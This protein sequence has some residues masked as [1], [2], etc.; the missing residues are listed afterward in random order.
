MPGD[1]AF[2]RLHTQNEAFG[3]S[4]YDFQATGTFVPLAM[5]ETKVERRFLFW[6]LNQFIPSLSASDTVGR[7]TFKTDDIL[8]LEIPLPP[9]NEHR[10]IV[11]RTEELAAKIEEARQLMTESKDKLQLCW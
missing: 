6:A 9:L 8:A 11:A 2:S 7:E 1:L 3:F 4:D 5:N 10:R